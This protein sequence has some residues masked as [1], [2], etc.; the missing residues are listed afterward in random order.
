MLKKNVLD[1]AVRMVPLI[2]LLMLGSYWSYREWERFDPTDIGLFVSLLLI[3]VLSLLSL[4]YVWFDQYKEERENRALVSVLD[5]FDHLADIEKGIIP[6]QR[7][8]VYKYIAHLFSLLEKKGKEIKEEA[9]AKG[10]FLSTMSH[11]IRTPLNGILGFTKLLKEMDATEDQKEFISLIENS[12]NNLISIVNDVLDL[13]KMNAEKMEIESIPF[14]LFETIDLTVASFAQMADQK[15]I[16]FGVLVDPTLSPY[17]IGDPTKL[18]QILT[19]LIGNAIKFTDTYG[20]INLFVERVSSDK[21]HTGLKFSVSDNGI[22]LS[23]VQQKTIFE[24]Y[25]QATAGTSRKYGGT[26]LGLT[27]SRKM[28]QL[29]GGELEV[30]SKENEGTTFFFTLSLAKNKDHEPSVYTDFSELSVGLALPVKSI[31]RQLDVNLQIY[32]EHLGAAFSFYYYEDLFESDTPVNLPDIM[33]FD[34]RYA[35]L[36]GEL[37]QCA[38][39]E[40]KSVLLTNGSLRA[41]VNPQQH[42]FT[43]VVL[44]PISLAKTIRILTNASEHKKEKIL[45]S[46]TAENTEQFQGLHALVADDNKI[47]CKLIKIILENLGLEVTV[48]NDGKDAVEMSIHHTYDIIFMDIEMPVMDGVEAC[49]HILQHETEQ[50][51]QHVP[52]IALTANTSSGDKE[53][54]MAKGMD[55]YAVKPL[56]IEALKMIIKEHCNS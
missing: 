54:Y 47:N 38:A 4:G 34:H 2:V 25:G 22:G 5:S 7:E 30:E 1:N 42:H 36:P 40:C 49:K 13:S 51:L 23:E 11:E 3:V 28:V 24:A 15:D 37:E 17:V 21:D 52:I 10:Q 32:I 56:D 39:L 41:R 26:G 16:E 53:K 29:M 8:E 48:V 18:S 33:I 45:T 27:I 43:D 31:D 20:K 12:S 14:H 50:R 19:N 46:D 35:R 6:Q 55:D 9:E 44:T